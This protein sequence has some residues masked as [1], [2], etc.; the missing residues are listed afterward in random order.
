[1]LHPNLSAIRAIL[2]LLHIQSLLSES[3]CL[4]LAKDEFESN[5]IKKSSTDSLTDSKSLV[6]FPNSNLDLSSISRSSEL[7]KESDNLFNN[8]NSNF[9]FRRINKRT[10]SSNTFDGLNE[11]SD[12]NSYQNISDSRDVP[13]LNVS[14]YEYIR[15]F[16]RILYGAVCIGNYPI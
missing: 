16:S 6:I 7:T 5:Q 12:L 4:N 2:V 11:I 13:S 10:N 14:Y 15:F 9:V 3:F 1:M 8:L